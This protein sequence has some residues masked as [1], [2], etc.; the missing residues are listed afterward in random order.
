MFMLTFDPKFVDELQETALA[1]S[2]SQ[3][4][5][6]LEAVDIVRTDVRVSTLLDRQIDLC[7]RWFYYHDS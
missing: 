2:I 1:T 4:D 6:Q 7:C 3:S 5:R